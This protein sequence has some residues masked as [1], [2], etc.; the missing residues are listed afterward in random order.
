[1]KSKLFAIGMA[2]LFVWS[3]GTRSDKNNVPENAVVQ[4]ED[5]TLALN[6]DKATCYNDA[7]NPS[8]N[9][10]EWNVVVSK[11]GRFKVW[12]SSATKDTTELSYI[13]SVK[14]SLLDNQLEVDPACD[15][16]VR[17]SDEV[18]YPYYRADSYMGSF[19]IS[20]PGEYNIQV[21]SEKVLPK[22]AMNDVSSGPADTRLMSVILTP[23]TR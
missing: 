20:E 18:S 7:V 12:L 3:C 22:E 17:N 19:Y 9:T 2:A 1:M 15:K 21:I 4:Q 11:P 14:V 10:A 8:S 16:I 5:G 6:L 23:N 13:N